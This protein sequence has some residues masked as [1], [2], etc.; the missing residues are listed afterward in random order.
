VAVHRAGL[1]EDRARLGQQDHDPQLFQH[2]ERRVLDFGDLR[3]GK[4]SWE[5]NGLRRLR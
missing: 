5:R 2:A 4:T 1:P 3:L